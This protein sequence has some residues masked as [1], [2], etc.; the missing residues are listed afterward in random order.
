[1]VIATCTIYLELYGIASLKDKRSVVRSIV[2]RLPHQ[3]NLAAAEVD[4]QDVWT[5]SVIGLVTVGN[6]AGYL[7]GRMEKAVKWI[8]DQRPDTVIIDYSIE[9]R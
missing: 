5:M 3:F 1:M 8:E 4:Y 2:R 6:D 7:H 9:F